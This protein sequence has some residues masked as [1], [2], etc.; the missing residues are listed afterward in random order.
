M[1]FK[2]AKCALATLVAVTSISFLAAPVG[3]QSH[4]WDIQGQVGVA[5]PIGNLSDTHD[6]GVAFGIGLSRW[7]NKRLAFH[8]GT[9]LDLLGGKTGLNVG[10]SIIDI[11]DISLWHY[12]AGIEIDLI[13][14]EASHVRAH[15]QLGLGGTT[16]SVKDADSSNEFSI[17]G[18][19][20][21]EYQFSP[22]FNGLVGTTLHIIMS[23]P[24]A[25]YVL[26][27]YLGFRYFFSD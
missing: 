12:N 25:V 8:L 27:L 23:D 22:D 10:G 11:R 1:S 19:A 24:D 18:G 7:F 20:S 14:P 21:L 2:W 5:V 26:P 15:A 3:A 6:P 16:I 9:G 13:N 17:N 4:E